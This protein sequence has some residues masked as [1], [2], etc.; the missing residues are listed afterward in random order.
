VTVFGA[1]EAYDAWY[2]TPLGSAAHAIEVALV[3]ELAEPQAG[4]RVLDVGCGTGI[5]AAWLGGLGLEV[6]GI[7]RD[8][9]LLAAARARAPGIRFVEGD[10]TALPFEP[11]AFDL[12]LAVTLFSFLDQVQRRRAAGE[13]LRVV[14]PGGRAVIADLA[15][16][17]LWAAQRRLKAWRG[18]ATWRQARFLGAAELRRLL[19]GA[20]G[21]RVAARY[22]LY[23]PPWEV[24]PL[25][26]HADGIE[27]LGRWLG[28]LGA[29]FVAARAE[30]PAGSRADREAARPRLTRPGRGHAA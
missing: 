28:P 27:R 15:R 16:L 21:T 11:D 17:S 7:D 23:L 30:R 22:A 9:L 25:L 6:T 8:P 24:Q 18:S 1:S 12:V 29:A 20:G 14:R 5:Y 10:A 3:A 13:L 2:E 19:T 4:Q 26:R